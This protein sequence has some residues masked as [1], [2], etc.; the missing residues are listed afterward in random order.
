MFETSSYIFV[1]A[2]LHPEKALNENTSRDFIMSRWDFINQLCLLEKKVIFGHTTCVMIH[3]RPEPWFHENKIGI[4]GG[5]CFGYQLNC[6]EIQP[7]GEM[8]NYFVGA[9]HATN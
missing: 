2:G 8:R 7:D 4:D 1:H 3:N 5:C 6:L 9:R